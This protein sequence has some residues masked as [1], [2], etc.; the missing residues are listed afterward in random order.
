MVQQY[1]EWYVVF[2]TGDGNDKGEVK[3]FS[4]NQGISIYRSRY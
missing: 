3:M 2:I 4:L 1:A